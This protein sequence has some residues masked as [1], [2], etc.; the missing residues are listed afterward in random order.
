MAKKAETKKKVVKSADKS[1]EPK[2]PKPK[3]AKKKSDKPLWK[4]IAVV[5]GY[6][7]CLGVMAG[8]A[9]LVALTMYLVNVTRDD[10]KDLNLTNLQLSL[11]SIIYYQDSET[12]EYE[13]YQ[14]LDG[15]ENR[16]WVD[17]EDIPQHVIDAYIAVEDKDFY[18]HH[19]VDIVGTVAAMVNEY[20]PIKLFSSKRGAST[21]TQQL[22]KNITMDDSGS[23]IE[24]AFRKLREIYRAF[25]LEKQYSKDEIL[26]AYL[27]TL[28]LSHNWAGVQAG[29][30]N[31]FGK[32]VSELTIAEAA[33]IA[34]IT[35]NP[36]VYNPY[37]H[38]ENNIDRR[39][40]ILY[41]MHQQGKIST[42]DYEAALAEE[43][44]LNQEIRSKSFV[45]SY[46]TD[47]VI[48]QVIEDLMEKYS[49]SRSEASSMVQ[50]DGLKIYSTVDPTVQSAMEQVMLNEPGSNGRTLFPT[51]ENTYTNAAGEKVTQTPQAAMVSVDYEGRIVGVVGGIGEKTEDRVL[52]RAVDALRQTGSTM[53]PIGAYGPALEYDYI[54]FSTALF[55][56]YISEIDDEKNPGQKRQWPR[57]YDGKYTMQLTPVCYALAKSWNTIAVRTLMLMG[58]ETSYD[59]LV[60]SVGISSLQEKDMAY[61]PLALGGLSEGISPLEM[62]AAYAIFGNEGRYIEPYCYTTVEDSDGEVILETKVTSV[63]ALSE[64]TAYIMNRM[65]KNVLTYGTGA[66]LAPK[67]MDAVGK[68]GTATDDK[69]HWFIGVT[70]YYSTAVWMGYDNPA[71]LTV[72]YGTHAPTTAWRNVMNICQQNLPKKSFAVAKGVQ[73]HNYCPITGNIANANC[74]D[75]QVGY[76]KTSTI[77][78]GFVTVCQ[79]H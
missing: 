55:D 75:Q 77:D 11:T 69:D 73:Q 46:F 17:L 36:S 58:V 26:E 49:I 76:Y 22:V 53:K 21:I 7:I 57:N 50:E 62:A 33:S 64:D 20:T 29:A 18:E 66:G 24:G 47:M 30:N 42:E 72:N 60:N 34:G 4:R 56:D 15:S 2:Q 74:P 67:Y 41:F 37:S 35:K 10:A 27:N 61:A 25:A 63:Q 38:P 48:D 68:T 32:D 65:M 54:H 16:I 71:T 43:L 45:N 23:G 8:S 9:V 13:E 5:F 14:R 59:F 78:N 19:G 70:P 28:R 79:A 1:Q 39:D 44:V 3:K 52:N 51:K 31:Y 40:D 6:L 12:G